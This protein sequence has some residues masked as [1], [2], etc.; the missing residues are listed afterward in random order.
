MFV[1]AT[2][3]VD[4]SASKRRSEGLGLRL[5][6][7]ILFPLVHFLLE[8]SGFFFVDKRQTGHT[9]FEFERMEESAV[10]VVLEGVIDFL[11]PNDTP[12]GGRNVDQFE[13]EGVPNQVVA[14]DG[15]AL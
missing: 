8:L 7:R 15:C 9:L 2:G 14:Q 4:L 3:D 6:A 13:P 10:L 5:L 1:R 11:V 12:V